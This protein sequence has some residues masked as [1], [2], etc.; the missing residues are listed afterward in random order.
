MISRFT[1]EAIGTV[2]F[3]V[4]LGMLDESNE[5][6]KQMHKLFNDTVYKFFSA[7][8]AL[9][10]GHLGARLPYIGRY[11]AVYQSY[12]KN[13]AIIEGKA[14]AF[15]L[16]KLKI[17]RAES[18][19]A[20]QQFIDYLDFLIANSVAEDQTLKLAG[21]MFVGGIDTTAK[22]LAWVMYTLAKNPEAQD[23]MAAEIAEAH[24]GKGDDEPLTHDQIQRLPYLRATVKECTRV[25]PA[26]LGTTRVMEKDIELG[27]YRIPA[28]TVVHPSTWIIGKNPNVHKDPTVFRPERW[29]EGKPNPFGI[30][31]FGHGP[32]MCPGRRI[33][34]AELHLAAADLCRRFKL[35]TDQDVDSVMLTMIQ[36]D[37]PLKIKFERRKQS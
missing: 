10:T 31:L 28:G 20:P 33:A 4:R 8:H 21:T 9:Q 15:V 34:E 23:K 17:A 26:V 37:R 24:K 7:S 2:C 3:G 35:S 12:I 30:L 18:K 19:D 6:Q 14:N 16:E 1:T 13:Y 11:N 5:E 32:R 22:A 25:W 36:P 29:L 27:G